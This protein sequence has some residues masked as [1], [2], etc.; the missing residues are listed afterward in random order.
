MRTAILTPA[1][2]R[3]YTTAKAA[4]ADFEADKDFIL[5]DLSSPWDGKPANKSG[6]VEG[7]YAHVNLRFCKQTKVCVVQLGKNK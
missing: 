4:K 2:G 6:L 1:Y 3:D 5:N 7:G